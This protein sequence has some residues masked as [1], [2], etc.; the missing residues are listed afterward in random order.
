MIAQKGKLHK[1]SR[2]FRKSCL[3]SGR[4]EGQKKKLIYAD[5]QIFPRFPY[6]PGRSG[7]VNA[8]GNEKGKGTSQSW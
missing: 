5:R 2:V 1:V 3:L 7:F 8:N 4:T 6:L